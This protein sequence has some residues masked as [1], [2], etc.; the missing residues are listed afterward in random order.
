[1]NQVCHKCLNKYR[2][3][4]IV[5]ISFSTETEQGTG[6]GFTNYY[7]DLCYTIY[8]KDILKEIK[9]IYLSAEE[10]CFTSFSVTIKRR[11]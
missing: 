6:H 3:P 9:S 5:E 7:C 8:K 4:S 11:K 1:M 2:L 10:Y